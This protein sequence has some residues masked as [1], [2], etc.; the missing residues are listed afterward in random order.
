M[1][2]CFV[3][4]LPLLSTLAERKVCAPQMNFFLLEE[5]RRG[6]WVRVVPLFECA[7]GRRRQRRKD[8]EE[9]REVM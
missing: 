6:T 1:I 4:V 5:V 8:G 9:H 3:F 7:L 2:F